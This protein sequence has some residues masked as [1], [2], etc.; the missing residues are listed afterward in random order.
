M[1]STTGWMLIMQA[2]VQLLE[3][4]GTESLSRRPLWVRSTIC[5]AL[6]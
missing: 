4:L 2:F 1:A 5:C 3:M 6:D